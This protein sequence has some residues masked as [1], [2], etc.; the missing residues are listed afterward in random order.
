[1]TDDQELIR[2]LR[3]QFAPTVQNC[4]PFE[5]IIVAARIRGIVRDRQA[6]GVMALFK[7]VFRRLCIRLALLTAI[8]GFPAVLFAEE[9]DAA[10]LQWQDTITGQI[11][12]FRRGDAEAA[13]GFAGF[14]FQVRYRDRDPIAFVQ[15]IKRSGYG[16]IVDSLAHSFGPFRMVEE[17][18]V[19]QVVK[20]RGPKQGLYQ[21]LYRLRA[22]PDGWRVHSVLLR[23]QP[24]VGI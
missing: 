10:G 5:G 20:L 8:F 7:P 21:A 11:E 24:G 14:S 2:Q 9:H 4:V 19:L 1:L 12:A 6:E 17:T 23:K 22:E 18:D 3:K 15:D 13:L 16:P